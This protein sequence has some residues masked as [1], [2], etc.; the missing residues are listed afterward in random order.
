[1]LTIL[2][3][4]AWALPSDA[5]MRRQTDPTLDYLE[6]GRNCVGRLAPCPDVAD[7]AYLLQA[8]QGYRHFMAIQTSRFEVIHR[9]QKRVP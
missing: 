8:L 2:G 1:V 4:A 5:T 7:A 3:D 6:E 9:E